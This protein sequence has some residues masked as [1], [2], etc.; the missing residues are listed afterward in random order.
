MAASAKVMV[1]ARAIVYVENVPVGIFDSVDYSVN[2]GAEP[3][4]ILG[5]F[6]PAEITP[7]SYEAVTLNCSG[8]RLIGQG[9]HALPKMPKLQDLLNLETVTI[10]VLDR[11]KTKVADGKVVEGQDK[12]ILV[13]KGCI[14]V[15]YSTGYSAKSTSRIRITYMGTVAYDESGD[16]SEGGVSTNLPGVS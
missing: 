7:T 12:P 13:A 3:I 8:F 11:Q 10:S 2:V 1:G 16:Q 14:P 4:H 6:S 9:G 15:S 5:R